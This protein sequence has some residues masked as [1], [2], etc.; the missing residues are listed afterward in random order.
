MT[1][2]PFPDH[3]ATVTPDKPALTMAESGETVTFAQLA[4]RSRRGAHLLRSRGIGPGDTVAILLENHPRFL[5]IAWA[6]Q[7]AGLRY[8]AL[9]S[10][11]TAAEV[12]YIPMPDAV[13]QAEK[14]EW[15]GAVC[16]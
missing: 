14:D 8:T 6:A 5:E 13:L 4:E 9:S 1:L 15:A 2:Q 16:S 7:R 3:H 11:L 12:G 10:R